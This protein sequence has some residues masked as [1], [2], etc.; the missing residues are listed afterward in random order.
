MRLIAVNVFYESYL[1]SYD[2]ESNCKIFFWNNFFF[3]VCGGLFMNN[4]G[5]ISLPKI[6]N[7]MECE[8]VIEN[9]PGN[10]VTIEFE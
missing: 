3:T 8:W 4:E 7:P 10:M 2:T 6:N 1:I 9:L 5:Y